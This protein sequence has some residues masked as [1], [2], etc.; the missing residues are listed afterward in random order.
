MHIKKFT[1]LLVSTGLPLMA[2]SQ[3]SP[4]T[5]APSMAEWL[6]NKYCLKISPSGEWMGSQAGDASVYNLFTDEYLDY[7]GTQLGL[8]NAIAN[9]GMAVGD[10]N[11]RATIMF[12]NQIIF[13][14]VLAKYWFCDLMG[15]T[16]DASRIC[17]L[18]ANPKGGS[19]MYVPMVCEVDADG[20]LSEP[21]FLPFPERDFFNRR[22][23]RVTAV[24]ISEDGKS[25]LGEYVDNTGHMTVPIVFKENTDGQWNYSLP[26]YALFN[27]E[28]LEAPRN[29]YQN[30]PHFPQYT[31]YMSTIE[32][33]RYNMAYEQWTSSGYN[34]ALYPE[35]T[36]Y[37]TQEE[38][39]AYNEAAKIYNAWAD[40]PETKA[41]IRDYNKY[42]T[43]IKQTSPDFTQNE[44]TIHPD[45]NSFMY[46]ATFVDRNDIYEENGFI[47]QFIYNGEGEDWTINKF[48]LPEE[49]PY[50]S[51]ILSD[52][53]MIASTRLMEVPTS[54]IL[55]PNSKEFVPFYE[56]SAKKYPEITEWLEINFPNG[57]GVVCMSDNKEVITGALIP[58]QL[59]D[60]DGD[61]NFYYSTYAFSN[62]KQLALA[63]IE[64]IISESSDGSYKV[65]NLQ[66][67]KKL[68]T[69]DKCELNSLTPGIYIINGKKVIIK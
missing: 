13:P 7:W 23:Q 4:V 52:G 19:T 12:N 58:D 54:F 17:G 48:D 21:V 24:W 1:I 31:E 55:E 15:I 46:H 60:Y 38:I 14:P 62:T 66:G 37:M 33:E 11:D 27:P 40:D 47:Y 35:P 69:K 39:D 42:L 56:W 18:V 25:V 45:G 63:G 3:E 53:T 28:G 22:P 9:N 68:D 26:S 6:P 43:E 65:Y 41:A 10:A 20:N 32:L 8:G 50:P 44:M 2:M 29:P 34:P 16:P 49:D 61:G 5:P 36:D 59:V 30:E 67:I 64:T 57:S 51:L